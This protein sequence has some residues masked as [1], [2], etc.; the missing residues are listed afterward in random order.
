MAFTFAN[1][2]NPS[3]TLIAWYVAVL[4][5]QPA[6]DPLSENP[7]NAIR[8][9]VQDCLARC[10]RGNTPLGVLAEFTAELR[11]KGWTKP[12]IRKVESAVRK[13]LAGVVTNDPE[14]IPD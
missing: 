11:D 3:G 13:V 12:D 10:Y 7:E 6:G 4:I 1:S 8:A 9:A 14:N 5:K 2:R